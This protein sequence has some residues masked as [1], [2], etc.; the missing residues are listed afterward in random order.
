[1]FKRIFKFLF[2][3]VKHTGEYSFEMSQSGP[4]PASKIT[5]DQRKEHLENIKSDFNRT[6]NECKQVVKQ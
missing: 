3:P 1:M 5:A 4:R 2:G 6:M